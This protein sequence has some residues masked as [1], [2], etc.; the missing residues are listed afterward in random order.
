MYRIISVCRNNNNN[1]NRLFDAVKKYD[2]S[3]RNIIHKPRES[4]SKILNYINKLKHYEVKQDEKLI[5]DGYELIYSHKRIRLTTFGYYASIFG[6]GMALYNLSEYFT[7]PNWLEVETPIGKLNPAAGFLL[8]ANAASLL[9]Y[10]S[11]TLLYIYKKGNNYK[12]IRFGLP[13]LILKKKIVS[14]N[15]GDITYSKKDWLYKLHK[16]YVIFHTDY[17]YKQKD[18]YDIVCSKNDDY[19]D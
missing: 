16:T 17:F 6:V 8:L 10:S 9:F 14:F 11:R 15:K 7:D 5:S 3:S 2:C 4:N 12:S 18:Y 1:N 19:H 13:G